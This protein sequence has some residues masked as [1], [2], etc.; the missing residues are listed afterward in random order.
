MPKVKK[1]VVT[2]TVLH[3]AGE[4]LDGLSLSDIAYELDEGSMIGS[5]GLTSLTD[6]PDSQ[7]EDELLQIGN[8]GE[9]FGY[10]FEDDSDEE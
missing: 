10:L 1:T 8:D 3:E 6:I 2:V 5:F 7:L 4:S 9:F